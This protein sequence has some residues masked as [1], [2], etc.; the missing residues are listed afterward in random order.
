MEKLKKRWGITSNIQLALIFLA[1]AL[2][3][4]FAAYIAKPL[5][6]FIGL[7]QSST[8]PWLFWPVRILL[9]FL[10]YQ[11]TLPIVGFCCGQFSFFWGFTKK[12][13]SRFGLKLN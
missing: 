9:V 5:T 11:F 3:G 1:F 13:L 2:N 10:V 12:M 4:S 6:H 8:N 7:D